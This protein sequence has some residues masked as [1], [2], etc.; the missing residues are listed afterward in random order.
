MG[1]SN[2]SV[3]ACLNQSQGSIAWSYCAHS[4]IRQV[5]GKRSGFKGKRKT[6]LATDFL[7][8]VLLL[9]LL[10]GVADAK[11]RYENIFAPCNFLVAGVNCATHVGWSELNRHQKI[12]RSPNQ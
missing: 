2:F 5:L 9:L 6:S 3:F 11:L 7:C 1:S 8:R 10:R 12:W 4:F